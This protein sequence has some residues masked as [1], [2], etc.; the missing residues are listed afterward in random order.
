MQGGSGWSETHSPMSAPLRSTL[1]F[2]LAPIAII[3][4]T[5]A[6]M[7]VGEEAA[8]DE[9]VAYL[10]DFVGRDSSR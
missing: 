10:E 8:R 3:E 1:L 6:G 2:S 5:I 9:I 7:L 4:V